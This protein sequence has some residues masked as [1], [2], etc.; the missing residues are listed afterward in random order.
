MTDTGESAPNAASTSE[1]S[2]AGV[3]A[4]AASEAARMAAYPTPIRPWRVVPE[5]NA[6][7][8]SISAS[9]S[10]VRRSAS[11]RIFSSLPLTWAT[12]ADVSTSSVRRTRRS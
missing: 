2:R 7:A 5:R 11:R 10:R 4:G 8:G 3:A 1:I 12:P 9:A 6:T